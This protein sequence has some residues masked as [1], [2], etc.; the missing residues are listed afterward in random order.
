MVRAAGA[1]TGADPP[2]AGRPSDDDGPF[3]EWTKLIDEETFEE[4]LEDLLESS[5]LG[6]IERVWERLDIFGFE[7]SIF[8]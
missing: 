2:V 4:G 5:F 6:E 7:L 3:G 8:C 1:K